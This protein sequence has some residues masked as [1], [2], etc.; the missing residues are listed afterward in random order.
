LTTAPILRRL[1]LWFELTKPRVTLLSVL[2]AAGGMALATRQAEVGW[3]GR[4]L[5]ILGIALS[6]GSANALNMVWERDS[7]GAMSRTARRPLPSG[8]MGAWE[9]TVV[10][11]VL[12]LASVALLL[13]AVNALTALIGV[14][15]IAAYVLVY[16]PLKRRSP[17]ALLVGAVPGAAPPLMGWA[18]ISGRIE[19]TAIALF[20]ILLV[21]Q[22]PHFLA[23]ALYRKDDYAAAGIRVV[24]VVRGDRAALWQM[25]AWSSVLVPLSLVLVPLGA[26]GALYA[27]VA[28]AL[29]LWFA[30]SCARGLGLGSEAIPAWSRR[31]FGASL[32][33]LPVLTLA[34]MLDHVLG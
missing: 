10:G 22:L 16:T 20:A 29:G 6:V 9:A 13:W 18:A 5:A 7:D 30:A 28:L 33:Y 2:M 24:P 1:G 12:G 17:L 31:V 8:R 14:A 4:A 19:P 25:L 32:V 15:A 27:V 11:L 21:W 26:A 23:I 3:L 34:L